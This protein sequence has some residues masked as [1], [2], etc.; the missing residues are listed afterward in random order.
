M[1]HRQPLLLAI[2]RV[3]LPLALCA[4]TACRGDRRRAAQVDTTTG[5]KGVVGLTD[6]TAASN[7]PAV[8]AATVA[9]DSLTRRFAAARASLDSEAVALRDANR[10]DSSYAAHYASFERRRAAA[11]E[12]RASRDRARKVRDSLVARGG[13]H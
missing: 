10:L 8:R 7:D 5:K 2:G 9:L 4:A 6:S 11:A 12:L 13:E 3:L 1:P